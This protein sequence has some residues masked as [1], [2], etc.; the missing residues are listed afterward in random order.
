[1]DSFT[2]FV[3]GRKKLITVLEPGS[4]SSGLSAVLSADEAA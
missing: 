3:K 1:L 2:A 4:H